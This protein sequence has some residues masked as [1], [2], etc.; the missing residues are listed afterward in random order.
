[1]NGIQEVVGSIPIIS[2]KKRDSLVKRLT[3]PFHKEET[4]RKYTRSRTDT[5]KALNEEARAEK[6]WA[7]CAKGVLR[8]K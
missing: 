7:F 1:M 4:K 3:S 6:A 5:K 2:T 8:W